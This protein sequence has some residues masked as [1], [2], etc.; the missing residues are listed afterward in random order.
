MSNYRYSKKCQ[1]K[2]RKQVIGAIANSETNIMV[3]STFLPNDYFDLE[4]LHQYPG[5]W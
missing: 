2:L 3:A 5:P 1:E 4:Q